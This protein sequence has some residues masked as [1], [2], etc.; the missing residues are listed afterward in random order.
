MPSQEE[1]LKDIDIARKWREAN[2]IFKF[3]NRYKYLKVIT[4]LGNMIEDGE[5]DPDDLRT[6][7]ALMGVEGV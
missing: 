5:L 2:A 4:M 7:R 3:L 1:A 6:I